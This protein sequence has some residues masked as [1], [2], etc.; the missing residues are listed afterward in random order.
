MHHIPHYR[1]GVHSVIAQL[2]EIWNSCGSFFVSYP[3]F[4]WWL[5]EYNAC[6]GAQ[7]PGRSYGGA[8]CNTMLKVVYDAANEMDGAA[9]MEAAAQALFDDDD[10]DADE[11]SVMGGKS[12]KSGYSVDFGNSEAHFQITWAAL[13]RQLKSEFK[14]IGYSQVPKLTT[15][16]KIDLSK[17][18]SLT[19][20]EFDVTKNKKRSLLIGCNYR[21]MEGAT[22]KASHDDIR[23]MKV[24]AAM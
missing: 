14:E 13:L 10:E 1:F 8:F 3:F 22:L 15:T 24:R 5:Q 21:N 17:P 20:E 11:P 6:D 2:C 4:W 12:F 9:Q 19:S 23:S 16:R 7:E 18:F